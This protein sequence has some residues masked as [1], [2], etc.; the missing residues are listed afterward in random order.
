MRLITVSV[1]ENFNLF[2]FGDDHE[3]SILRYD[4]GWNKLCNMVNSEYDG[5]KVNFAWHHGDPIEAIMVDDPRYDGYTAKPDK[6]QRVP[7]PLRQIDQAVANLAPIK[8][9]LIGMN[10]GNHPWKLHR[11]GP[12]TEIICEKLNVKYGTW[13]NV[14]TW[15]TTRGRLLFKSFHMH[16]GKSITSTA[17]DPMRRLSNLELILKR[18][19]RNKYG[20]CIL[21][22]KGHTHK[23]L[24]SE[25]SQDLYIS[26][27]GRSA[28][29]SYTKAHQTDDYIHPDL[30]WYV[31][32]GSFLRLYGK[33]VS[34]YAEIAEYD[35]IELGFAI[36]V[37]RSGQLQSVRKV[38]L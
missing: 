38:V 23:L 15:E 26:D 3:G 20:S 30:R 32:T 12:I 8:H 4:K 10:E 14:I 37:V 33:G 19:L 28:Q 21:M 18:Q 25:P 5:C 16:G 6:G 29:H 2:L 7:T 22:C 9:Y 34:G 11:F 13:A 31:N 35:P 1:P 17:D 27:D 36:G 24:I